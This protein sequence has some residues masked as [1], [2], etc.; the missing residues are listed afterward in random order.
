MKFDVT[1]RISEELNCPH[2]GSTITKNK[3]VKVLRKLDFEPFFRNLGYNNDSWGQY[4]K[5][6]KGQVDFLS[7]FCFAFARTERLDFIRTLKDTIMAG[8][9]VELKAEPEAEEQ[10]E[11]IISVKNHNTQ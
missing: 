9:T 11:C 2:C 4:I 8:G 3:E 10:Q 7:G 5:L 1:I 6:T